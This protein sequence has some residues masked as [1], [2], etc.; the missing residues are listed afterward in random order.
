M[1][2]ITLSLTITRC[3]FRLPALLPHSTWNNRTCSSVSAAAPVAETSSS[4]SV[5]AAPVPATCTSLSLWGSSLFSAAIPQSRCH[6]SGGEE[7][8]AFEGSCC[9]EHLRSQHRPLSHHHCLIRQRSRRRKRSLLREEAK[10]GGR[11]SQGKTGR[12]I[13][14]HR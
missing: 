13:E 4:D 5:A 11:D 12:K 7:E 1:A 10:G 9:E 2:L 8:S 14:K 3:F 6:L